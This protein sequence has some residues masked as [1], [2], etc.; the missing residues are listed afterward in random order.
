[1]KKIENANNFE[2]LLNQGYWT[3]EKSIQYCDF[4]ISRLSS[5]AEEML[6]IG[7]PLIIY[8]FNN[9][10][11]DRILDYGNLI[12][13]SNMENLIGKVS[14]IT[15]DFD[16]YNNQLNACRKEFFFDYEKNKLNK[17]MEKIYAATK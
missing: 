17:E 14:L 3:P 10:K 11:S 8:D 2:I 7:K 6:F 12:L 16:K 15:K 13:S 1:M 9:I 4:G 5:L